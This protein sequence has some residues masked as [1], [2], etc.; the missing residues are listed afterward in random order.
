M[1]FKL[2]PKTKVMR[3]SLI[4]FILTI[5]LSLLSMGFLGGGLYLIA[6]PALA[7]LF[8]NASIDINT[9]PGDWVW[10]AMISMPLLWSG[11]FLMAGAVQLYLEKLNWTNLTLKTSYVFILLLWNLLIWAVV[12]MNIT[13]E[14]S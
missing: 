7:L 10:P 3:F 4:A 1:K 6:A 8:P 5:I 9:W 2:F 12:L 13:P 14:M 11:G